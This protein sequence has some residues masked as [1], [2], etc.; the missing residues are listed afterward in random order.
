MICGVF[1]QGSGVGNQL[2]RYV[3]TRV[4]AKELGVDFGM[5]YNPDNSGKEEWF[6]G[7]S[8]L[9]IDMGG[10]PTYDKRWQEKGVYMN[11]I[12]IR[13]YDPEFNFIQDGT[14]IDGEFQDERYWEDHEGDVDKWLKVQHFDMPDTLCVIGFRGGEFAVYPDLFLT[15]EYWDQA[16]KMMREI[17]P[18][19]IFEVH[20]DDKHLAQKFFPDFHVVHDTALNW[21]SMRYSKYA[22][23]ANSSFFILPRWLNKGMT[24]APR[25]WG[26]RNI[27]VWSLPQNYYKRF[28]HI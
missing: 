18:D 24:I 1:H 6:K 4:R 15:Q 25:G 14:L 22:I 20:T 5:I 17:N 19:M 16:I 23:I 11:E 12:D 2:H 10:T 3:A 28:T 9:D 27:Q 8:F 13:P 7:K 21:R 26:R